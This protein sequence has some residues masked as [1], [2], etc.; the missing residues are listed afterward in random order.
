MGVDVFR[1]QGLS[2]TRSRDPS[3]TIPVRVDRAAAAAHVE[4]ELIR[5]RRQ[6]LRHEELEAVLLVDAT[7]LHVRVGLGSRRERSEAA[8]ATPAL[9]YPDVDPSAAPLD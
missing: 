1:H 4:M 6:M 9:A 2:F 8:A 5:Q 7:E 3:T